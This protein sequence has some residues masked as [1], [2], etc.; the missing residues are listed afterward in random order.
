MLPARMPAQVLRRLLVD[1]GVEAVGQA[2]AGGVDGLDHLRQ[3]G[4][5]D[6]AGRAARGRTPRASARRCC[7]SRSWSAATKVP[8]APSRER[9]LMAPRRRALACARCAPESCACASASITGPTSVASRA[10]SPTA[11]S[12]MAP[13][14]IAMVRV[15]DVVLQVEDAQRRA[16]LAGAVEGRGQHVADDLLGQRGAVDDHRVL[17][18]GLGD[19]D[20][21]SPP[22]LGELAVDQRATSVEPVNTT[23]CDARVGD[24]RR[25][26]RWRR[27]RAGAAARRRARRR[28]GTG[29]RRARRSAGSARPAWRAPGCRRRA[30]PRPGR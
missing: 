18:A 16:A 26:R 19:Q 3:V 12:S 17:A 23:P 13:L 27:R 6:S 2:V 29:A 10:G 9:R 14:S 15:G 7:R 22:A 4:C 24:Q 1:A 5:R 25:A 11:S 8:C 28:G 20:R 30:L 21:S